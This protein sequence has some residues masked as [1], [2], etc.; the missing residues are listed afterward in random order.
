MPDDS[1]S[2]RSVVDR[3]KSGISRAQEKQI[4]KSLSPA[5]GWP[6]LALAVILPLTFAAVVAL[7]LSDRLSL[8]ICLPILTIVSYAH[9][10]LVDESVHS[11]VVAAPS[12]FTWV[13]TL[14]G[15]IGALGMGSGW[16][17]LQRTHVLHHSHTNTERDPDIA[18]KGT[19]LQLIR[20]WAIGLPFSLLPMIA[21]KFIAP[22]RF[23]RMRKILSMSEILQTSAVTLVTLTLLVVA[24][25]TGHFADWLMLWFLPTRFGVLILNIFFQWL[26]HYPFDRT[27]RRHVPDPAAEPAPDAPPVAQR[28]VLQLRTSLSRPEA[29]ADRGR[30]AHRRLGR[31]AL[32]EGPRLEVAA[33]TRRLK[34]SSF[35]AGAAN[36][37]APARP[38]RSST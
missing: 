28:A 12:R 35:S 10:T 26:P 21:V 17:P 11:N 16:P 19:L 13:N 7:G 24:L 32:C 5:I 22:A 1:A 2:A 31:G 34:L 20:K 33:P 9:Y 30:F 37:Y 6:T 29:S 23:E 4:A 8:W 3:S 25:A 27:D 14:T 36:D 18:V 38:R 15:W